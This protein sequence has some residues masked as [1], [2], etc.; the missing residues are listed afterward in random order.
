[1][2]RDFRLLHIPIFKIFTKSDL[3][4][5]NLLFTYPLSIHGLAA[6]YF[7]EQNG[8]SGMVA[9][10]LLDIIPFLMDSL[11]SGIEPLK[12]SNLLS[13]LKQSI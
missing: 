12:E 1:M 3:L 13:D 5:R 7:A 8:E 6:D 10:D 11:I 9:T 4:L 2:P